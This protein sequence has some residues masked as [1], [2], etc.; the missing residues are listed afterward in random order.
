MRKILSLLLIACFTLFASSPAFAEDKSHYFTGLAKSAYIFEVGSDR[1]LQ[2]EIGEA[3]GSMWNTYITMEGKAE[4]TNGAFYVPLS[5]VFAILSVRPNDS[6]KFENNEYILT[7]PVDYQYN[8]KSYPYYRV[9]LFDDGQKIWF[10][11]SPEVDYVNGIDIAANKLRDQ[12][13]FSET[14]KCAMIPLTLLTDHC[15]AGASITSDKTAAAAWEGDMSIFN[16]SSTWSEIRMNLRSDAEYKMVPEYSN[17]KYK[18]GA[19]ASYY[20]TVN[21]LNAIVANNNEGIRKYFDLKLIHQYPDIISNYIGENISG[22]VVTGCL[23]VPDSVNDYAL[24]YTLTYSDGKPNANHII[25]VTDAKDNPPLIIGLSPANDEMV[26]TSGQY[27]LTNQNI[28]KSIVLLK[29]IK[30][31]NEVMKLAGVKNAQKYQ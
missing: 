10:G 20:A 27:F 2:M 21:Y 13:Y 25:V 26:T 6:A 31:Y 17:L 3:D 23:H 29:K 30:K 7:Q 4:Y 16:Y 22:A 5:A 1:M 8:G 18:D 12:P 14:N 11:T 9:E 24:S 28:Q 15:G 19:M